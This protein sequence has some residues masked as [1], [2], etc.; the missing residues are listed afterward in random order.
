[1]N[2]EQDMTSRILLAVVVVVAAFGCYPEDP[3]DESVYA[4]GSGSSPDCD[5]PCDDGFFCN[6]VETCNDGVCELGSAPD[7]DDGQW[8]NG[9]EW[10]DEA[11]DQCA[12]GT[13]P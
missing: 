13:P 5:P 9:A 8:C 7:C 12:S 3:V 4:V 2:K 6:G 11:A 1:M 10:C